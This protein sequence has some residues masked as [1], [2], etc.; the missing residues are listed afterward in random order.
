MGMFSAI[1]PRKLRDERE[2]TETGFQSFQ[3]RRTVDGP[4]R[5][6]IEGEAEFGIKRTRTSSKTEKIDGQQGQSGPIK[7]STR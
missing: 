6:I 1:C 3:N 4:I 5:P 7:K 2:G